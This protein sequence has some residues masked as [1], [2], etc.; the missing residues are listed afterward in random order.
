[1]TI[2]AIAYYFFD[3]QS[4]VRNLA[5]GFLKSGVTKNAER[6]FSPPWVSRAG[7]PALRAARVEASRCRAASIGTPQRFRHNFEVGLAIG[8]TITLPLLRAC[9]GIGI[10]CLRDITDLDKVAAYH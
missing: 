3:L 2:A 5:Q 7:F 1:M 9:S 4:T 10:R 6:A 8:P